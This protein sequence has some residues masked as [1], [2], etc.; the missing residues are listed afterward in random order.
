LPCATAKIN[1]EKLLILSL[2]L[3]RRTGW[4]VRGASGD[5]LS[6]VFELYAENEASRFGDGQRFHALYLFLHKLMADCGRFDVVV[7]EQVNGGTRGRQTQLFN[8]YRGTVMIWCQALGIPHI[9]IAVS[10]I[11]KAVTGTGKGKK[12]GMLKAVRALGYVP[13]DDNECDAIGALLTARRDSSII[14]AAYDLMEREP[15]QSRDAKH[16]DEINRSR[17][18]ERRTKAK[19]SPVR[20][21]KSRLGSTDTGLRDA[22]QPPGRKPRRKKEL[23][24]PANAEGLH[25]REI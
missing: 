16:N 9:G 13:W 3:G 25:L 15:C 21:R 14:Q 10:T 22:D 4:A 18:R 20:V 5:E 19:A 2:D 11:K 24:H 7:F 17:K 6:G 23:V 12:E 8:G 1:P